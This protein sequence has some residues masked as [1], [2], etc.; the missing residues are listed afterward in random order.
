MRMIK[1]IPEILC[2]A[3]V[4]LILP[5]NKKVLV[6][7]VNICGREKVSGFLFSFSQALVVLKM[8]FLKK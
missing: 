6:L 8:W 1:D 4:F 2:M 7:S 3:L 5:R